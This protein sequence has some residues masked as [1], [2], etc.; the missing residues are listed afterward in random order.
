MVQLNTLM[1]YY[2]I[3]E[4]LTPTEQAQ[5]DF[6]KRRAINTKRD[7][8]RKRKSNAAHRYQDAVRSSNET[9]RSA[10]SAASAIKPS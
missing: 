2:E 5:R 4:K 10:N 8:A 6:E 9:I 1:R 7:A 3:F